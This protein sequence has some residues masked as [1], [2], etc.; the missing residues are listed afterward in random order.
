MHSSLE[1][2]KTL[3]ETFWAKIVTIH[4]NLLQTTQLHYMYYLRL[5][6]KHRAT[7]IDFWT[8]FQW[9]TFLITEGNSYFF[10]K[11]PLQWTLVI[12]NSVLSPILFTNERFLLLPESMIFSLITYNWYSCYIWLYIC[13][14]SYLCTQWNQLFKCW[15][16]GKNLVIFFCFDWDS[17]K[18]FLKNILSSF[19]D[20]VSLTGVGERPGMMIYLHR[21]L[22]LNW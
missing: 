2:K 21:M 14:I 17:S 8:F 4:L 5:R 7:L 12:V 3:K 16:R 11:Y 20:K 1:L 22:E 6:N 18:V 19:W 10:P 9:A 13:Y 15:F